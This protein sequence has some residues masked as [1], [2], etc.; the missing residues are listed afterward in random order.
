MITDR[1]P[2]VELL[3]AMLA[4]EETLDAALQDSFPA[5][6]PVAMLRREDDR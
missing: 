1:D 2:E 5:S 3:A 4:L 6:D